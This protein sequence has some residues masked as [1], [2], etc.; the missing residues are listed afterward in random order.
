MTIITMIIRTERE[1]KEE[2]RSTQMKNRILS[3]IMMMMTM[4]NRR[5][6]IIIITII[7][8]QSR[9]KA[10]RCIDYL[11]EF[12]NERTALSYDTIKT[13]KEKK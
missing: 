2:G 5:Q 1:V 8:I 10:V 12:K 3:A 11:H 6:A 7:I 9:P 13:E 4:N